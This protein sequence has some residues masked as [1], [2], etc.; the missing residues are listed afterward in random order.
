[1]QCV[2]EFKSTMN[3]RACVKICINACRKLQEQVA[4]PANCT[5]RSYNAAR[6]HFYNN[7]VIEL[8][9]L[10]KHTCI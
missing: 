2:F 7:K 4:A 6:V 1:M 3:A 8:T 9:E 10:W 5:Q